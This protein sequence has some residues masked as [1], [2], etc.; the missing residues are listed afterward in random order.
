MDRKMRSIQWKKYR[1]V[2]VGKTVL[3]ND[4]LIVDF[5]LGLALEV[6]VNLY[7]NV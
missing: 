1:N 7:F 2:V 6:L 3:K 5:W 4:F